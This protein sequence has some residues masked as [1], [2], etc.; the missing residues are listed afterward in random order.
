[1]TS[2]TLSLPAV[3]EAIAARRAARTE[4]RR[5]ERELASYRT[6]AERSELAAILSRHTADEVR[7]LERLLSRL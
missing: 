7:P 3:R 4:Q 2:K 6:P 5:L 1:M